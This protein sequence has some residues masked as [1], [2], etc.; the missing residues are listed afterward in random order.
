MKDFE[1]VPNQEFDTGRI[2]DIT[3][4]IDKGCNLDK[5]D[6]MNCKNYCVEMR[7][8]KISIEEF[9]DDHK[10]ELDNI[11]YYNLVGITDEFNNNYRF[12]MTAN[13]IDNM[14][15]RV[16][17][18]FPNNTYYYIDNPIYCD[19]IMLST[20]ND[21]G[22]EI[23]IADIRVKDGNIQDYNLDD[24]S[25]ELATRIRKALRYLK[26]MTYEAVVEDYESQNREERIE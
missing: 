8:R 3:E 6:Y 20:C 23:D 24:D 17:F 4:C 22:E 10:K 26:K 25:F 15:E 7:Q 13:L 9:F 14:F 21:E 1:P 5:C 2:I 18:D 12:E 11:N 16:R 19:D